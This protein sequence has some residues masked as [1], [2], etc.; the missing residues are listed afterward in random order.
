VGEA[1]SEEASTS[2]GVQ[3]SK[4]PTRRKDKQGREQVFRYFVVLFQDGSYDSPD[5]GNIGAPLVFQLRRACED[6]I[7]APAESVEIDVWLESPGGDAHMAYK[8]AMLLRSHAKVLRV[9]VPDYAKSAATLLTLAAD[10]IYMAPAAELGPLDA[11]IPR[12]GGLV[13]SISALDIA[14]SVDDLADTAFNLALNHG[15]DILQATRLTR[16]ESLSM[17]LDFSAK[18]MEPVVRQLDPTLIHWSNTLLDVSAEYA[19]RLLGMRH[20][21]PG[22]RSIPNALVSN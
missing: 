10:E 3:R 22:A 14:R 21:A 20:T 15:A 13:T 5:P 8:L 19:K 17:M 12:E 9:I 18:F 11:Q 7:E 4:A 6:A 16:S 2:N 1:V